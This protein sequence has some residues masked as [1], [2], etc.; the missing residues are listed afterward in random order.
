MSNDSEG[1]AGF[2]PRA[3][4]LLL[5]DW[6]SSAHESGIGHLPIVSAAMS[7]KTAS[8]GGWRSAPGS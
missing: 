2:P 7:R 6:S 8:P 3:R 4:P 1:L 5:H